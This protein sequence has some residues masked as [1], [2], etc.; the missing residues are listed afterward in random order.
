MGSRHQSMFACTSTQ[1]RMEAKRTPDKVTTA[2]ATK[3]HG[4]YLDGGMENRIFALTENR[5]FPEDTPR[6]ILVC[7][8]VQH[9][10]GRRRCSNGYTFARQPETRVWETPAIR[11]PTRVRP[12][13]EGT[14]R[15]LTAPGGPLVSDCGT[16]T[17]ERTNSTPIRCM[18]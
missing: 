3:T 15:R 11:S 5:R 4:Q 7:C 17:T 9:S 14:N 18:Y 8:E 6:V 1:P 10:A 12:R 13:T 2:S 16:R